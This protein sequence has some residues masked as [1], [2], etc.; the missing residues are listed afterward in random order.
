MAG[1]YKIEAHGYAIPGG[2]LGNDSALASHNFW[3]LRDQNGNIVAEIQALATADS[4]SGI[5]NAQTIGMVTD[6]LGFYETTGAYYGDTSSDFNSETVYSGSESDVLNKWKKVRDLL[7]DLNNLHLPYRALATDGFNSNTG[8]RVTGEIMGV[9]V[10]NIPSV[11]EPGIEKG[12]E[13]LPVS[14]AI[15]ERLRDKK[16]GDL[17]GNGIPDILEDAKNK[18]DTGSTIPSPIVLDLDGDGVET[19]KQ[20]TGTYFD[21]DGNGF[22]ES[23]GWAD[24]D[25]GL[26]VRDI[27]G[28]GK[29][30]SGR[31]LFGSETLL[32]N[33]A[34]AANG[35]DALAEL[36]L[37]IN[38]GNADGQIDAND[39]AFNT[40]KIWQDTNSDG[41][42]DAGELKTLTELGIQ[43]INLDYTSTAY[44]IANPGLGKSN[45]G[46]QTDANNNQHRQIGS[47]TKL[48]A[49]GS[50]STYAATDVWLKINAMDTLAEDW[51]E[52]SSDIAQLPDIQGIGNVYS[53]RQAMVR[54]SALKDI[55]LQFTQATTA[56]ERNGLINTLIYRWAGVEN[57]NPASRAATMI[58]GNAIGDARKLEALEE[59][60]GEEW[61]G[62]WCWGTRDHNPHGRAAPVL[63]KAYNDFA[64]SHFNLTVKKTSERV[65]A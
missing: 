24:K 9:P 3:V 48:N 62:V 19:T 54:D 2:L 63:L 10:I 13:H 37:A 56:V 26:L 57:I 36:D 11:W 23:T 61:Y 29:I 43:S 42:T 35:F 16:I 12:I 40:L 38:G 44:T 41:I 58:Y 45:I 52:V 18:M 30:D 21:H 65:A 51:L 32:T 5:E 22:A 47:Y 27:D 33:G 25:D 53:L 60:V 28:N 15:K 39:S 31:E 46:Y 50:T 49:D 14:D 34:K 4:T 8:Y 20:G 7:D 59:F 64:E 55:V 6:E 1:T 17:N